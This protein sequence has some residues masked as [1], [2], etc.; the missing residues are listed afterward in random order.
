MTDHATTDP[1]PRPPLLDLM[2]DAPFLMVEGTPHSKAMDM[3]VV[4]VWRDNAVVEVPFSERLIGNP[5]TG[6][7]HGGVVTTILDQVSGMSVFC[8]LEK[9]RMI[10]TLDL[11]IDYMRAAT[12][13]APIVAH[14]HCHKLTKNIAFVRASAHNGDPDDPIAAA[15][16]AFMLQ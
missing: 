8:S 9:P 16:A 10:A 7:V 5:A 11:R 3:R 6:V 13:E 4:E 2:E 14:G 1:K 15:T 12:P